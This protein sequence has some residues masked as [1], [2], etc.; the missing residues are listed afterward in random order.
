MGASSSKPRRNYNAQRKRNINRINSL[1][2]K[3]KTMNFNNK[4]YYT[5][6]REIRSLEKK[7]H[8]LPNSY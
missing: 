6:Q 5:I 3:L 4:N 8:G 1:E 2:K 7:I